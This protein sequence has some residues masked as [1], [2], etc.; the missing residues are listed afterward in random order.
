MASPR[1]LRRPPYISKVGVTRDFLFGDTATLDKKDHVAISQTGKASHLR[2]ARYQQ[3]GGG[4][5]KES[6]TSVRERQGLEADLA[7]PLKYLI[8]RQS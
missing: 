7:V 8:I 1:F 5:M 2:S 3:G 4:G 6:A